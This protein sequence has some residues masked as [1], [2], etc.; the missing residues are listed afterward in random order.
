MNILMM[1]FTAVMICW[2]GNGDKNT[3]KLDGGHSS[4]R[5]SVKHMGVANFN[6]SFERFDLTMNTVG[7]D[8]STMEVEFSADV[9]S[10]NTAN[11][12]RDE[13]LL[14]E[15]FF[16]ATKYPNLTFKS[17]SAKKK[18]KNTFL[19]SGDFTMH[20][21]TKTVELTVVQNATVKIKDEGKEIPLAG[22]KV[23]GSVKRSDYGISPD[24]TDLANE[25]FLDADL[26]IYM[27]PK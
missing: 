19:V 3:W 14:S 13:H 25:V 7:E 17:K 24:F 2:S 21:I 16:D 23:S 9:A 22:L 27:E 12:M 6:G 20:G 15:D 4:M 11:K 1:L 26:E 8:F 5:F 18:G 10:I